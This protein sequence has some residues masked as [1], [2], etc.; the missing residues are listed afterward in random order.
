M[1]HVAINA[2]SKYHTF[3]RSLGKPGETIRI[4]K[5][6]RNKDVIQ[7]LSNAI[8]C[9]NVAAGATAR[10]SGEQHQLPARRIMLHEHGMD[11]AQPLLVL[12]LAAG[13]VIKR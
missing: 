2:D 8:Q 12:Q 11:G 9:R 6:S 4:T 10:S 7:H 3:C 13:A 1:N 5:H